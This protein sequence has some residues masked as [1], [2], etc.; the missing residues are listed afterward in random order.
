[1]SSNDNNGVKKPTSPKMQQLLQKEAALKAEK[2][3]FKKQEREIERRNDTRRKI[4]VGAESLNEAKVNS[5][6]AERIMQRLDQ[7]LTR[8]DDRALFDLPPLEKKTSKTG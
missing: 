3:R 8:K 2:R 5:K 4:L 1:M 7:N 6:W